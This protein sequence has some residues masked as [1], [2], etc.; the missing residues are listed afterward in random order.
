MHS[1]INF[2][3]WVKKSE[4]EKKIF[5]HHFIIWV[6]PIDYQMSDRFMILA[7]TACQPFVVG[8]PWLT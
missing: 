4:L 8:L 2:V 6:Q 7:N 5:L 3:Y 1:Y